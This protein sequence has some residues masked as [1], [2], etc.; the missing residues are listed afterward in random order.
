MREGAVVSTTLPRSQVVGAT[1]FALTSSL[2][3]LTWLARGSIVALKAVGIAL[4]ADDN[5]A[6]GG[7]RG[8]LSLSL[9]WR[10]L[11]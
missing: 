9:F 7:G 3:V 8:F 11:G 1:L 4:R 10:S 5:M 6:G 2:V